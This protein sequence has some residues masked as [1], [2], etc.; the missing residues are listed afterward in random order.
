LNFLEQADMILQT[1][2]A[3]CFNIERTIIHSN[4]KTRRC[5]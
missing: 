2:K 4:I 5:V 1:K 3:P